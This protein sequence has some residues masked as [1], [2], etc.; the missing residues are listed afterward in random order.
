MQ[1]AGACGRAGKMRRRRRRR[2]REAGPPQG[3]HTRT[4]CTLTRAH[5]RTWIHKELGGQCVAWAGGEPRV[6]HS[7]HCV[8]GARRGVRTA[9]IP[10]TTM[11]PSLGDP[12]L[13]TAARPV[14]CSSAASAGRQTLSAACTA[15]ACGL[16]RRQQGS[17]DVQ[18]PA[19]ACT[20][21]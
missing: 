1:L 13:P 10:N 21:P 8:D 9:C 18:R 4:P 5:A 2:G 20:G 15:W 17:R 3:L 12:P 7:R 19:A 14:P 11:E 6:M 16:G